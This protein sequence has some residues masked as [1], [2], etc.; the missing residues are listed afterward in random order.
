MQEQRVVRTTPAREGLRDMKETLA[1]PPR[2]R[3][4]EQHRRE[5]DPPG[6]RSPTRPL[7]ATA[8]AVDD[9][10]ALL[11]EIAN[12]RRRGLRRG[13]RAALVE[14]RHRRGA[15]LGHL[16]IGAAPSVPLPLHVLQSSV[17]FSSVSRRSRILAV[18]R[19]FARQR[20]VARRPWE[21]HCREQRCTL[22][23]RRRTRT[24][25]AS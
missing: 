23:R 1:P 18:A 8:T 13:R 20:R 6:G 17:S 3:E 9:P 24:S 11:A 16:A 22:G 25:R 15:A 7:D 2:P 21:R 10:P 14:R 4:H 19:F 12:L 5:R